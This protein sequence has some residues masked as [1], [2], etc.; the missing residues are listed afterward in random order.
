ML[1]P[2][3]SIALVILEQ[4]EIISLYSIN[5]LLFIT[6]TV[7]VYCAVRTESINLLQG[8]Q[9]RPVL[10]TE[11]T[12]QGDCDCNDQAHYLILLIVGTSFDIIGDSYLSKSDQ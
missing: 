3:N 6:E 10:S 7:F 9:T 2:Q 12:S 5:Q 1:L 4:L 8:Q 11:R